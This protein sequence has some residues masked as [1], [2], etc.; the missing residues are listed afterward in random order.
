MTLPISDTTQQPSDDIWA[1]SESMQALLRFLSAI[2]SIPSVQRIAFSAGS[3][4]FDLWVMMSQEVL[5]DAER[6]L[7]HER[8]LRQRTGLFPFNVNLIP[9]SEVDEENLPPAEVLF[10]R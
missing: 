7:L 9:L 5:E 8:A 1:V 10:E 4:Q 3:G 2:R 6:I